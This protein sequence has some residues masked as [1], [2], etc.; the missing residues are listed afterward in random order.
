MNRSVKCRPYLRNERRYAII[1]HQERRHDLFN[2]GEQY[3]KGSENL[4]LGNGNGGQDHP[5]PNLAPFVQNTIRHYS[6]AGKNSRLFFDTLMCDNRCN[7]SMSSGKVVNRLRDKFTREIFAFVFL[8]TTMAGKVSIR[9][10]EASS[11]RG[12]A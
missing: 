2:K 11:D 9:L 8:V 6:P 1:A 5:L 10:P 4:Q 12:S 7:R 3:K